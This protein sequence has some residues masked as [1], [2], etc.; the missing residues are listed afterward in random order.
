[1]SS[2]API[3]IYLDSMSQ[4]SRAVLW[5]CKLNNIPHT[6]KI[7]NIAKLE[8]RDPAFAK[9]NPHKKLPAIKDGD[10]FLNESHTI[11]RYLAAKY[12]VDD[13]W[14]PQDLKKRALVDNFLD[15]HHA[16]T[17]KALATY[18][19]ITVIAP[20]MADSTPNP[21]EI[22]V[23]EK[24]ANTALFKL[25]EI[26]LKNTKFINLDNLSIADLSA[27]CEVEQLRL[28]KGFDFNFTKFPNVARWVKEMESIQYFGDV[29]TV[30]FKV[31]QRFKQERA[32]L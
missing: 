4:P 23:L 13:H 6:I 20:K 8:N 7:I 16:N 30:L 11:L 22:T 12:N 21:T 27:I 17:R 3:T 24:E 19:F 9:I 15:W 2:A 18:F 32:K 25:N 1:M 14:Y 5:F 31:E 28:V 10:F 29:H 26:F